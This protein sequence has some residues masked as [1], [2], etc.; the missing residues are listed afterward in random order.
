MAFVAAPRHR[1]RGADLGGRA[2]L[3][4][5]DWRADEGFGIL[6]LI[7]TAPV[8]VASWISL[9]YHGSTLAPDVFG[10]GDKVLH[11]VTAGIGVVEGNG[12]RLRPGLPMQSVHDGERGMHDPLR[13][14][15]VVEAPAEAIDGILAAHEGVARLFDNG[16]L[17]LH[18]MDDAG[19]VAQRR[20]PG[21]TWEDV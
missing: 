14:A 2:F 19:R 7:L 11:N 9:Q 20:A 13:L 10:G 5:Y 8:V 21:G 16:W 6:E 3:H 17:S 12:G 18:R 1:T 4:G 15:V